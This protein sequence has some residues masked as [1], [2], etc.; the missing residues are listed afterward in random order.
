MYGSSRILSKLRGLRFPT[1]GAGTSRPI[2]AR[3]DDS[4][5]NQQDRTGAPLPLPP[6]K[7]SAGK[8]LASYA[9]SNINTHSV[10]DPKKF[11]GTGASPTK[12]S[13]EIIT[14]FLA[15]NLSSIKGQNVSK[16]QN[17]NIDSNIQPEDSSHTIIIVEE[18][19]GKQGLADSNIQPEGSPHIPT[20]E[21]GSLEN[22]STQKKL[23]PQP[24]SKASSTPDL[25]SNFS[26]MKT[27]HGP[28]K[29][30]KSMSDISSDDAILNSRDLVKENRFKQKK[31]PDLPKFPSTGSISINL[32]YSGKG[33]FFVFYCLISLG[34]SLLDY[35]IGRF[36]QSNG[37]LE[38]VVNGLLC[39]VSVSGPIIHGIQILMKES[40]NKKMAQVVKE[41]WNVVGTMLPIVTGLLSTEIPGKDGV[42]MA[43]I[44]IVMM[45]VQNAVQE[46][47]YKSQMIVFIIGNIMMT[48]TYLVKCFSP[49]SKDRYSLINAIPVMVAIGLIV[50]D[51]VEKKA[52]KRE[53]SNDVKNIVCGISWMVGTVIWFLNIS[54]ED[55]IINSTAT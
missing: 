27:S 5:K 17:L 48:S 34:L 3:S 38:V 52:K 25:S 32:G 20:P 10:I 21:E 16:E 11:E 54:D 53:V 8:S 50:V 37:T 9:K 42:M 45:Y 31:Q 40:R 19:Q 7:T 12:P 23:R 1:N 39:I 4:E 33:H 35:A 36:E 13:I 29:K 44:G 28:L 14:K 46:K 2:P 41:N 43:G 47:M 49:L 55:V 22:A 6:K 30:S 18:G 15:K 51:I 24:L 26:S